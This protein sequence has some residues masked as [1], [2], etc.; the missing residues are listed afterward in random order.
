MVSIDVDDS[1]F[2]VAAADE[3]R[4]AGEVGVSEGIHDG[5]CVVGVACDVVSFVDFDGYEISFFVL[6]LQLCG[7][8]G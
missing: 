1:R 2:E 7:G 8:K 6:S 5:A 3:G 4:F